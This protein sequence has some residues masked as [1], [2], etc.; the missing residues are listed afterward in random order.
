MGYWVCYAANE[1]DYLSQVA[2]LKEVFRVSI[3]V[4][5]MYMQYKLNAGSLEGATVA[6]AAI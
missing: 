3:V 1:T 4:V 6:P 5:R 2:G